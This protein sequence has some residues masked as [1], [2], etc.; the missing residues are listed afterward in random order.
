M[1]NNREMATLIVLGIFMLFVLINK[2]GRAAL[3]TVI[4]SA[5][6]PRLAWLWLVYAGVLIAAVYGLRELGFQYKG[7]NKDAV[8]WAL[9]A[10]LPLY[11]KFDSAARN[12]GSFRL[13]YRRALT[14]TA[15]VEFFVN[16]YVFPLWVELALQPLIMLLVGALAVAEHDP[17]HAQAARLLNRVM[18]TIGI[19]VFAVVCRNL[20]VNLERIDWRTVT[21]QFVQPII[22]TLVVVSLTYPVALFSA[23]EQAFLRTRLKQP[24]FAGT[25]RTK[26][27]LLLN[28]HVRAHKVSGFSGHLPARLA[29]TRNMGEAFKLVRDYK[30]GRTG[31]TDLPRLSDPYPALAR[32]D[33]AA[34]L[35]RLPVGAPADQPRGASTEG[36]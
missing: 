24:G 2:Q 22:L 4:R 11:T 6:H 15:A 29:R 33:D 21:L 26:L 5:A 14:T 30:K 31:P 34:G 8:V 9:I 10:G 7:A 12:A 19:V 36:G 23:Y 27:A 1:P 20:A 35:A 32:T 13:L 16:L 17:A 18:A 28:L 25:A 3:I